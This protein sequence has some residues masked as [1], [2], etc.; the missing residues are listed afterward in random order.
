[1]TGAR[2]TG[3]RRGAG[4]EERSETR[5]FSPE[6]TLRPNKLHVCGFNTTMY[7][8]DK[9]RSSSETSSPSRCLEV[10]KVC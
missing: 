10:H 5:I 9:F 8:G 6:D 2:V 4:G 7:I 1:M 3:H